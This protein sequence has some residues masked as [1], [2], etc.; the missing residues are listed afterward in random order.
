MAMVISMGEWKSEVPA[1]QS[2]WFERVFEQPFFDAEMARVE[3][4][5][6]DHPSEASYAVI[7]ALYTWA[8]FYIGISIQWFVKYI[9]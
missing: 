1:K 2:N 3:L 6:A 5:R 7:Y 4:S 8:V 9:I